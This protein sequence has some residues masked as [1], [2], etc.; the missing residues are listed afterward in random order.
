[1]SA[2]P[3]HRPWWLAPAAALGAGVLSALARTWRIERIGTAE[4]DARAAAGE[5]FI[6]AFWHARML[7]LV[8]THRDMDAAV[9][10]SRHRDGEII[11]RVLDRFGFVTARGSSTRGGGAGALEMIEFARQGRALG[12]TPDG[13]RGPAERVKDGVVIMASRTGLPILPLATTS[14][15]TW[16]FRS[17]DRFRV[18]RPFARV[19]VG[20]G[21]VIAVPAGLDDDGIEHWRGV[22]EQALTGLTRTLDARAGSTLSDGA[23]S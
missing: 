18:P 6:Y 19:I 5:R 4:A 17:W 9:L 14:S 3:E 7:P 11:A 21:D 10:I 12:I 15:A 8:V 2:T 20:Y 22:I 13:P 1:M 23:W 16:R